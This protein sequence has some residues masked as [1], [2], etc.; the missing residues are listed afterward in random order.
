[1][2]KALNGMKTDEAAERILDLFVKT[3]DNNEFI[4]TVLKNKRV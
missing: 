4:N 1:M 2:R 3:K